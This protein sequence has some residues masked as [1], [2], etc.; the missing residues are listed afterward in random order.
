MRAVVITDVHISPPEAE[1]ITWHDR[2]ALER[3]A[4]RYRDA[5]NTAN[6]QRADAVFVLGDLTHLGDEGSMRRF[7]QESARSI[8]PV[9]LVA[10]N[11]DIVPDLNL[12]PSQLRKTGGERHVASLDGTTLTL[13]DLLVAGIGVTRERDAG[14]NGAFDGV[15]S[16]A[17]EA[18]DIIVSHFPLVSLSEMCAARGIRYAGDLQNR[19]RLLDAI[20]AEERPVVVLHGHLHL[21]AV[22]VSNA[23]LQLS[24]GA[25]IEPPCDVALVE[26]ARNGHEITVAVQQLFDESPTPVALSPRIVTAHFDGAAWTVAE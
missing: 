23:V 19:E 1:D 2:L 7:L 16:P 4:D 15:S 5:I 25:L 13:G 3:S 18:A 21:R 22:T 20:R 11:H 14:E 26:I 24:F 17:T 6:N 12:L 9:Y 8:A 10:G